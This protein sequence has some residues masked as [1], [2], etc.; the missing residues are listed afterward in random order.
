MSHR[1]HLHDA[2][3]AVVDV[4]SLLGG[5]LV[6]DNGL[7]AHLVLHHPLALLLQLHPSDI[8]YHQL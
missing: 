7:V 4:H 8:T 1:S 6:Y 2:L 3:A 5:G